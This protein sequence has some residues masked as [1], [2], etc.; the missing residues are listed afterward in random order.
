MRFHRVVLI[1]GIL[2]LI[3][4][5]G[6]LIYEWQQQFDASYT[7]AKPSV[8]DFS[9]AP[10]FQGDLHGVSWRESAPQE[11]IVRTGANT[12]IEIDGYRRESLPFAG[13]PAVVL[14]YYRN[15]LAA[16]G[17]KET[18]SAEG[19]D[20]EMYGY[21]NGNHYVQI[22]VKIISSS[23]NRFVVFYEHN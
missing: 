20:G 17:W 13:E 16:G 2:T 23:P 19:P 11:I 21:E 5:A 4:L 8:R 18:W 10:I 14:N 12:L 7:G 22:G 6:L 1:I 3:L 9:Q 15:Q